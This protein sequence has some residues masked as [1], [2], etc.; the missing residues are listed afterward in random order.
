MQSTRSALMMAR[1]FRLRVAPL[2]VGAD[3]AEPAKIIR[4][5]PLRSIKYPLYP[6]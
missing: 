5:A 6:R 3:V 1:G 2:A 4:R